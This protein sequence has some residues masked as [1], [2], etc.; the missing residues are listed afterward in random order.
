MVHEKYLD[1]RAQIKWLY[2]RLLILTL[3]ISVKTAGHN[4]PKRIFTPY[5]IF[6]S[7]F[8]YALSFHIG[9]MTDFCSEL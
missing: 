9:E 4:L 2:S 1:Q 5:Y 3:T 8:P 6:L 7:S